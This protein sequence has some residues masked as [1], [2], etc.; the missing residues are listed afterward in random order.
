MRLIAYDQE[1]VHLPRTTFTISENDD[2][3]PFAIRLEDGKGVVYTLRSLSD[4]Q[5]YILK[6][7]AKSFDHRRPGVQYKT[8]FMIYISV[9]SFPY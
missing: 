6:V 8:T 4:R 9:S 1:D 3:L 5:T 2:R 7:D